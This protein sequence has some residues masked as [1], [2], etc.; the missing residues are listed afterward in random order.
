MGSI[1]GLVTWLGISDLHHENIAL[2]F[3]QENK[4]QFLPLDIE[5]A[6]DDFLSVTQTLLLPAP[7]ISRKE[8]GL[9]SFL[10]FLSLH[11]SWV[12]IPAFLHGFVSTLSDLLETEK[13]SCILSEILNSDSPPILSRI[14]IRKTRDYR[15]YLESGALI[16]DPPFDPSEIEQLARKDIPVF[17][18]DLKTNQILAPKDAKN[19][20]QISLTTF[21]QDQILRFCRRFNSSHVDPAENLSPRRNGNLLLKSSCLH[22][23][24]AFSPVEGEW[25]YRELTVRRMSN[26]VFVKW[27]N[28]FEVGCEIHT[29]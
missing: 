18:R 26:H 17:Y 20:K 1:I 19:F 16:S 25:S 3:D 28:H 2:G 6:L 22:F 5:C 21:D 23:M 14:L 4:F 8:C 9:A 12:L 7:G 15:H 24:R 10:D 27:L 29:S 13:D 11:K